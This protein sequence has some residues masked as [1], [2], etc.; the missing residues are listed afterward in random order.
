[1][2]HVYKDLEKKQ[3]FSKQLSK[4]DTSFLPDDPKQA[5]HAKLCCEG[6][7][8][9]CTWCGAQYPIDNNFLETLDASTKQKIGYKSTTTTTKTKVEHQPTLPP[10]SVQKQEDSDAD[11]YRQNSLLTALATGFTT[12]AC[13]HPEVKTVTVPNRKATQLISNM[14]NSTTTRTN[15]LVPCNP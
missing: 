3:G 1:M 15:Q 11:V 7:S 6:P 4:V 9:T 2:S 14:F 13:H 12:I 5:V 8:S 10:V